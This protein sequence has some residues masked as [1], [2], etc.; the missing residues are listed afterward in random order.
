MRITKLLTIISFILFSIF[1]TVGIC[2][3]NM[4]LG[5]L[6]VISAI[7]FF[8]LLVIDLNAQLDEEWEDFMNKYYIHQGRGKD[9]N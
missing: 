2:T 6:T 5:A 8:I 1:F 4:L 3:F 7:G 9:E